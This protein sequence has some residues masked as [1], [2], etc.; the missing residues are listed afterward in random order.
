MGIGM[1]GKR[2]ATVLETGI[3]ISYD[4][5]GNIKSLFSPLMK[6]MRF[7]EP[8]ADKV[9]EECVSHKLVKSIGY[10]AK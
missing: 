2:E 7:E 9:Y 8:A 1:N 5:K 4:K 6:D 10:G 3:V